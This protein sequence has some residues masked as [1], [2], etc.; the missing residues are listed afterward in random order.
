M[1]GSNGVDGKSNQT[2]YEGVAY[3]NDDLCRICILMIMNKRDI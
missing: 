1:Q 3:N 2:E